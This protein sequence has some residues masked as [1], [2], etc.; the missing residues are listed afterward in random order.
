MNKP[1]DDELIS[2]YKEYQ[3]KLKKIRF[4][5]LLLTIFPATLFFLTVDGSLTFN[6]LTTGLVLLFT[7]FLTM[8]FYTNSYIIKFHD[9]EKQ[10]E[11]V[12]RFNLKKQTTKIT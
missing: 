5:L 1:T 8:T 2:Q 10:H 9:I 7:G 4:A 6:I 3:E 11:R 12:K